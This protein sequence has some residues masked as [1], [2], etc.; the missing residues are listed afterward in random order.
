MKVIPP[1]QCEAV[2]IAMVESLQLSESGFLEMITYL[3]SAINQVYNDVDA[4]IRGN[5]L[6]NQEDSVKL[7][8]LGALSEC[9]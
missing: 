5:Y 8:S 7:R 9:S 4:M 3:S 6:L 2:H 1:E